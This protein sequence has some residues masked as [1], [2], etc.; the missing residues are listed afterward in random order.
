MPGI[1]GMKGNGGDG[2]GQVVVLDKV[3]RVGF[4]LIFDQKLE[5]GEGISCRKEC[6]PWIW[7]IQNSN[8]YLPAFVITECIFVCWRRK[9][10][11]YTQK[12]GRAVIIVCGEALLVYTRIQSVYTNMCIRALLSVLWNAVLR[13]HRGRLL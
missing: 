10:R 3:V 9:R 12:H 5:R 13:E 6:F 7:M 8:F 2:N 1:K 4:L 11:V